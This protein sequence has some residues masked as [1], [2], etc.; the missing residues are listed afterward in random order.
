MIVGKVYQISG[1]KINSV[2]NNIQM[3]LEE[4]IASNKWKLLQQ[5]NGTGGFLKKELWRK[6]VVKVK[7]RNLMARE[8][9]VCLRVVVAQSSRSDV[10]L[11]WSDIL[12]NIVLDSLTKT[13]VNDSLVCEGLW[14][15][16]LRMGCE[17][18]ACEW[19]VNV[20]PAN[21]LWWPGRR[22]SLVTLISRSQGWTGDSYHQLVS[23]AVEWQ[24]TLCVNWN[25]LI[26]TSA[27]WG[28]QVI[29]M[30]IKDSKAPW[31]NILVSCA[32]RE[33]RAQIFPDKQW[34]FSVV[35]RE[36]P[37]CHC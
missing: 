27:E 15:F 29:Q 6:L 14:T 17:R 26:F 8:R 37:G 4:F 31:K 22:P 19:V 33:H 24:Q 11:W 1:V 12:C 21:G 5:Q 23:P 13:F 2:V 35:C 25:H 7:A 28:L 10:S 18:W 20:E 16:S 34:P 9:L 32:F 30:L 3:L 36:L